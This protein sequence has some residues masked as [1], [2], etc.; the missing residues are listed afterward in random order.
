[1]PPKILYFDLGKVL[2]E[3]SHE[4]M[5]R[6]MAEVAGITTEAVHE[7]LFGDAEN[8]AA[9][10]RYETGHMSTDQFFDH[11][12]RVTG[13]APDRK[14]LSIAVCD[15]FHPIEPMFSLVRRLADAG[16]RLAILSNT[17]PLQWEYL[18]DGRHPQLA[19]GSAASPFTWAIVSYEA[20]SMKPD[21]RIYE[22]A[23][24]RAGVLP[25]DVFFTD[26]RLDNVAGAQAGGIDA[27]QFDGVDSL[28][29]ELRERNV[30]GTD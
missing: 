22:T 28:V 25:Q 10:V 23:V 3:F 14:Q 29:A 24:E 20:G 13:T 8:L 15:I 7:A 19:V 4:I 17:N 27:V 6:Q 12:C 9:L 30:P 11:F 18:C 2:V 1:M 26:D 5:C 21:R 16:N